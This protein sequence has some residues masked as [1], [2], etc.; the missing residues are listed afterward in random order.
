M[1]ENQNEAADALLALVTTAWTS[2]ADGAPIY[3]DNLDVDRPDDLTI[4]GRAVV[5]H[6]SGTRSTLGGAGQS[7]W[8]RAGTMYVQCF[9]KQG[10]AVAP[11]RTL[12]DAVAHALEDAPASLGVRIAD[13]DINELGSDGTYFQINVAAD[14][15]YDRQS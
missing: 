10:H 2:A 4:Y 12:S 3:Y 1:A 6:D 7:R 11:I 13:V 15:T 9:I 8:R 5:R 14:F